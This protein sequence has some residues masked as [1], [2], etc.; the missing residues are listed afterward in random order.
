MGPYQIVGC[1]DAQTNGSTFRMCRWDRCSRS[2]RITNDYESVCEGLSVN[3]VSSG[4]SESP[5]D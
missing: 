1:S 2:H 5:I 4:L 3:V